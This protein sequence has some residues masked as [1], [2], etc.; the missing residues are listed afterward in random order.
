MDS[1]RESVAQ[2]LSTSR[3][4]SESETRPEK[5]GAGGASIG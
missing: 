4:W 2:D 5:F 1:L 3:V